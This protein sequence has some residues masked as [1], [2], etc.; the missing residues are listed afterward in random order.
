MAPESSNMFVLAESDKA[1]AEYFKWSLMMTVD[2]TSSNEGNHKESQQ[3]PVINSDALNKLLK[4]WEA[5]ESYYNSA[6]DRLSSF[7]DSADNLRKR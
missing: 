2:T 3:I 7:T 5:A 6:L 1:L 4:Q